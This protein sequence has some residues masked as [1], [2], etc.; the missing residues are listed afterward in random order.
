MLEFILHLPE[1]Q[2][3]DEKL[4]SSTM[5]DCDRFQKVIFESHD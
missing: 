2:F 3:C 1:S 4:S 5:A